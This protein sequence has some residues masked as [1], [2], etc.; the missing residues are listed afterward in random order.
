MGSLWHGMPESIPWE[1]ESELE[2]PKGLEVLV[3][4][5]FIVFSFR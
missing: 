5:I 2:G 4:F 3:Y 1:P